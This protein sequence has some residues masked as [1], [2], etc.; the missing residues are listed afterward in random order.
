[1]EKRKCGQIANLGNVATDIP[2]EEMED[3]KNRLDTLAPYT[4]QG[5][6]LSIGKLL[7]I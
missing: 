1:V 4:P 3:S 7:L 6:H 2:S 5:I